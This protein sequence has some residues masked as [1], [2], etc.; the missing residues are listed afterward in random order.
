MTASQILSASLA[1]NV[2]LLVVIAAL[3][4]L[5]ALYRSRNDYLERRCRRFR[6]SER[7]SER[8]LRRVR[9]IQSFA[10][11]QAEAEIDR[12]TRELRVKTVMINRLKKQLLREEETT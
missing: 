5:I 11:S 2:V 3:A 7:S 12:L 9:S 6:R 4:V 10:D 8:Q 1:L